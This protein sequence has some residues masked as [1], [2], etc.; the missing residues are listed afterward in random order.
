MNRKAYANSKTAAQRLSGRALKM[1]NDRIKLRD[2][3]TCKGCGR[4]C[5]PDELQVDHI[6]MLAAGGT[7][8][9]DNLQS[10]CEQCH[11]VKSLRERGARPRQAV[12]LDGWPATQRGGWSKT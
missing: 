8:S 1:R 9:D 11:E 10:L 2:Q 12:G 3:Y 5:R 4:I 7:E 6:T